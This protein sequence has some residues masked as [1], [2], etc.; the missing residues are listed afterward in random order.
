LI[1]PP[2]PKQFLTYVSNNYPDETIVHAERDNDGH[3]VYLSNGVEIDFD[4]DGTIEEERDE[5]DDWDDWNDW[6]D[7]IAASELP[8]SILNYLSSEYP[9]DTIIKAERDEGMYEVTLGTGL[10]LTF[11]QS[12]QLIDIDWD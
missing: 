7:A 9:G 8:E 12:G 4:F 2:F 11:D 5:D 3:E 1:S 6:D 10:E